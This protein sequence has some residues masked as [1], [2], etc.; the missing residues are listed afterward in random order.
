MKT[1][2][3]MKTFLALLMLVAGASPGD[4]EG[5]AGQRNPF[6]GRHDGREGRGERHEG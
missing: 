4:R 2:K 3:K 1:M 6:P 5:G